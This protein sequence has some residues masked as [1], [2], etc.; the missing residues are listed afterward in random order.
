MRSVVRIAATVGEAAVAR[1]LITVVVDLA[2]QA[3]DLVRQAVDLGSTSCGI[4][5]AIARMARGVDANAAEFVTLDAVFI[6]ERSLLQVVALL[7]VV[8]MLGVAAD[9][10][11]S[12]GAAREQGADGKD[13][14]G[15]GALHGDLQR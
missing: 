5:R 1:V 9:L 6:F 10:L 7:A 14:Q 4:T 3:F 15:N 11:N 2:L 8:D 13:E 12:A